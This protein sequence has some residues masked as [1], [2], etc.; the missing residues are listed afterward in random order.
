MV[1]IDQISCINSISISANI[2]KCFSFAVANINPFTAAV[3]A[4]KA[5]GIFVLY[6][7]YFLLS[8]LTFQVVNN[9]I[10]INKIPIFFHY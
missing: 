6:L 9:D 1:Y 10:C 7:E 4:I 2:L 8:I 5:S 3:A